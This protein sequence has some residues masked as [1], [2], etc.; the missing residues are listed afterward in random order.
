M[1]QTANAGQQKQS[2]QNRESEREQH[3]D[4]KN[5][6]GCHVVD[7]LHQHVVHVNSQGCLPTAL[8]ISRRLFASLRITASN[9]RSSML[10]KTAATAISFSLESSAAS[11]S[12]IG[13]S[14]SSRMVVTASLEVM[15]F[16]PA[17][18]IDSCARARWG[19]TADRR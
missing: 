3:D 17:P 15:P 9:W 13:L 19:C 5:N 14:S 1:P 18:R 16:M 2:H 4:A 12:A 7:R 10:R 11:G 8:P 6:I